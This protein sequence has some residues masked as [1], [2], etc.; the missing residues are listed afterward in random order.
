M[1]P[2][3]E[4]LQCMKYRAETVV[5]EG[6]PIIVDGPTATTQE[7]QEFKFLASTLGYTAKFGQA[8]AVTKPGARI[9]AVTAFCTVGVLT[10]EYLHVW[11][12]FGETRGRYLG[13]ADKREHKAL[14]G[15]L[16]LSGSSND[17]RFHQL[18][19]LN[20]AHFLGVSG[21]AI[22]SFIWRT[23]SVVKRATKGGA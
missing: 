22:P 20:Y 4:I 7:M 17:R 15:T 23:F 11:N 13:D 1:S 10:D 8:S 21:S 2:R 16:R 6:E 9:V 19:L 5:P 14:G 3:E 18:E 12:N